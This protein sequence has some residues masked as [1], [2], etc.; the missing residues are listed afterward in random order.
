MTTSQ[1]LGRLKPPFFG[2]RA[3][4]RNLFSL[5]EDAKLLAEEWYW[6]GY[7][8]P[9]VQIPYSWLRVPV[10][11]K[12]DN[13]LNVAEVT[14]SGGATARTRDQTSV[15]ANAGREWKFDET[16]D[17][18]VLS[19]PPNLAKWVVDYYSDPRPRH[20]LL[21]LVLNVR[22]VPEIWRILGVTQG[23]RISITGAPATWPTGA[24]ELI[25][26]GIV[27]SIPADLRTVGWL[28]SPV[29]GAAVGSAGPWFRTDDSRLGSG[30]DL[31]PY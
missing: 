30:T 19:D 4:W 13:P 14:Q 9:P 16:I 17:S 24:T 28:A 31:V 3:L 1:G 29:V 21:V 25:V 23:R 15:D 18:I 11:I 26:E 10:R 2:R 7:P 12:Q 6:G 22:T 27:H 5:N 8:P 20:A